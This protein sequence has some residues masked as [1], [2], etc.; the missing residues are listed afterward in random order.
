MWH[1]SATPATTSPTIR[2]M[3]SVV[4]VTCNRGPYWVEMFKQKR[5]G[6]RGAFVL[7]G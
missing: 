3:N 2:V 7:P 6:L 5:F 4:F 1:R